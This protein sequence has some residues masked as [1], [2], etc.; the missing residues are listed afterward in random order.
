MS[1]G[2]DDDAAAAAPAG[3]DNIALDGGLGA[4]E[5]ESDE[6]EGADEDASD[7][8]TFDPQRI[9]LESFRLL[10][11]CYAA[12]IEQVHRRKAMLKLQPK[13]KKE[14]KAKMPK[15]AGSASTKLNGAL[16][17]QKTDFNPSETAHIDSEVE[18]FLKLDKWR[19]DEMPKIVAERIG[20]KGDFIMDKDDLLTVMSWKT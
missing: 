16:L 10:L 9:S 14:S 6:D 4:F 3:E 8:S 15:G 7:D 11:S 5:G 2:P 13:P 19:Y 18:K 1:H 17:P 20:G 12:T